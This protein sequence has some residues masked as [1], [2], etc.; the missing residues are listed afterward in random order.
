MMRGFVLAILLFHSSSVL[1]SS[2]TPNTLKI[3]QLNFNS[4]ENPNDSDYYVR[5]HRFNSVVQ[6]VKDLDIDVIFLAEAWS[7]RSDP[8]VAITM[9]RTLGYDLA[10][11]LELGFPKYFYEADA[12]LTKKSLHM[13]NE[14]DLKLP[15]SAPEIGNGKTWIIPLGAVSYAVGVKIQLN[16]STP[17]Y[18]YATHLVGSTLQDKGDQA[19]A[20]EQNAWSRIQ[21][22]GGTWDNAQVII[23]GDFNSAPTDPAP[24]DVMRDG[25]VDSFGTMHPGDTSCS[26]CGDPTYPWFNPFTIASGLV[27][28]QTDDKV[29]LRDDYVFVHSPTL[30][31]LASTL[32][33]TQPLGGVWMS[34][35][36]GNYTVLGEAGTP[37]PPNPSH[38]AEVFP[39]TQIV[40]ITTPLFLC[41]E[42]F[43]G[44]P[45]QGTIAA[46]T[47][48]GARGVTFEN[49]SDFYVDI[50]VQGP[51]VIFAIPTAGLS[52][53]D[54]TAVTF[55]TPG[56]FTYTVRNNVEKPNPYRA[57]LSGTIQVDHTGY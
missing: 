3:L 23:A 28:S 51:G 33:F 34:D 14:V 36:Y 19:Q 55:N 11:R 57:E 12:V 45:C 18:V 49:N 39:D 37:T 22:D 50:E 38:D 1:A 41:A 10:Y 32:V 53:G 15:H 31:P 56:E 40:S 52:P 5:D 9:A 20:I 25:F 54:R 6:W 4:E 48:E 47:V 43:E 46:A 30:K 42:D 44:P 13:S 2:T 35:H 29:S 7:Y 26:D 8:T 16:D 21:A 24:F 27:P 17:A